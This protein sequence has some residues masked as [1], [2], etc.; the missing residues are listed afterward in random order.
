[1]GLLYKK[2]RGKRN[3]VF[4]ISRLSSAHAHV[5]LVF[6]SH[7]ISA[8]EQSSAIV[9]MS[10]DVE[11]E[12]VKKIRDNEVNL[13]PCDM[14][15]FCAVIAPL[16]LHSQL[17][18]SYQKHRNSLNTITVA[19]NGSPIV[20]IINLAMSAALRI[21]EWLYWQVNDSDWF[22]TLLIHRRFLPSVIFF[23]LA[24]FCFR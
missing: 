2:I 5:C 17:V 21:F 7:R 3:F 9:S 10:Y 14:D 1:V 8:S 4:A 23:V 6:S 12:I 19:D 16:H 15:R 22:N 20:Q 24:V 18:L 11:T 13:F